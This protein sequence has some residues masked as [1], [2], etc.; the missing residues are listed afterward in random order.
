[1][2]DRDVEA[3]DR[4]DV[5]AREAAHGDPPADRVGREIARERVPFGA[6]R[7]P[8]LADVH[9]AQDRPRTPRMVV[10]I[11]REDERI[12]PSTPGGDQAGNDD[13]VP[14]I[15]PA[16]CRRSRISEHAAA[17]RSSQ[18]HGE[19]LADVQDDD[20]S[21]P[22]A[23]GSDA[24]MEGDRAESPSETGP[25]SRPEPCGEEERDVRRHQDSRRRRDAQV[26]SG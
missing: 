7:E 16:S 3:G 10:V 21:A 8:E 15:E 9:V 5:A 24:E 18:D 23:D 1:M 4:R 17:L 12:Q 6:G 20:A 2:E 19:P 26:P 14:R 13:P 25:S 22:R 11:V